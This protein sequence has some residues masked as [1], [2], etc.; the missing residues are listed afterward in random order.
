MS[1]IRASW[2]ETALSRLLTMRELTCATR[3]DLILRRREAP[4]R[5]MGRAKTPRQTQLGIPAARNAR[6]MH[7][8][9]PSGN[10]GRR[11][12]RCNERT[13]SLA[14]NG[15]KHASKSPQVRRNNGIPCAMVF[16]AYTRSP[17]CPGLIAT[18]ASRSSRGSIPASGDRDH[19]ISP[20]ARC[21]SS[22]APQRPSHPAPNVRDDRE[23]PLLRARDAR[24]Q[25]HASE[26]RKMVIFAGRS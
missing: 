5:R 25:P 16:P 2:F 19:T 13:R 26:K 17:R 3:P 6:V 18:V 24:K 23:A 4:S 14:C 12:C 7:R 15:R 10:R 21:R 11:E 8:R 22:A 1:N 9:C 20:A